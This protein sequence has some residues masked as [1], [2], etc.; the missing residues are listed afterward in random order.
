[1]KEKEEQLLSAGG[2]REQV[3]TPDGIRL[4][5]A[6]AS[7][8]RSELLHQAGLRPEICPSHKEERSRAKTPAALVRALS[9][10]KAEDIA[11]QVLEEARRNAG[12]TGADVSGS[13][14]GSFPFLVIGAD[15]I[16]VHDGEVLGKPKDPEDAVRMLK[17][18][19]GRTHH[20]YTGVT[21][22]L[23]GQTEILKEHS[24]YE[25]TA[26][27][28]Y[29]LTEAEIRAYV[30][31]GDPMDKAGAYGIQGAFGQYI[32]G[33]SGDYTNV[34]GLPLGRTIWEI[35]QLLHEM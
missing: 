28:V 22:I 34:V 10:T 18:L 16:V 3:L 31:S 23:C 35:K 6:S 29:P 1:M 4:I 25:K 32:R 12:G 19:S 5:L 21:L 24:F 26:V 14:S 8:R 13:G 15:T 27:H 7:P 17:G 2:I 30:E 20:V 9:R 11:G 33:I